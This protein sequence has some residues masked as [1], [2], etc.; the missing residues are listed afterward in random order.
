MTTPYLRYWQAKIWGLLHD[1]ALKGLHNN[2]GRGGEGQWQTLTCMAGWHSPK[3]RNSITT[4]QSRQWL[5]HVGLCDLIASASDRATIGRL[6]SGTAIDYDQDGLE[7]RHLLSGEPQ[8][9]KLSQWHEEIIKQGDNRVQW[10]KAQEAKVLDTVKG[11]ADPRQVYWW[12]WRCYPVAL[13]NALGETNPETILPLLPAETRLPDASLWS[14]TSTTSAIAGAL[15]G[16]HRDP[17]QYPPANARRVERQP[18]AKYPKSYPHLVAFTFSPVQEL[19]KASRKMRDF[20]AGS[21]LL[22]FLSARVC[23]ELAW[24]Y[25]PDIF[26]YPCLYEQ[27]LIDAWLLEKYPDFKDWIEE[28]QNRALLTAGFPNVITCILPDNGTPQGKNPVRAAMQQAES[29]LKETWQDLG[30]R[31]LEDLQGKNESW[32]KDLNPN[33]WEGWLKAQWQI[34]WIATP[35]GDPAAELHQSPIQKASKQNPTPYKTWC[36]R[37]NAIAKPKNDLLVP[38]EQA[39]LEATYQTTLEDYQAANREHKA[40]FEKRPNLNVGSWWAYI[41]DQLRAQLAAVKNARNWTIPTAFGP[42]STIS[43]IGPVVGPMGH[44]GNDWVTEGETGNVWKQRNFGLFDGIEELNA[45]EVVKRGLSRILKDVLPRNL[46]QGK[47]KPEK[48]ADQAEFKA[49]LYYPDLNAGVVGWLKAN[50]EE[51]P[52]YMDVYQQACDRIRAEFPWTQNQ[53]NDPTSETNDSTWGIPW[54]YKHYPDLPEPRFI[55][56]GWLIEDFPSSDLEEK[57]EELQKLRTT[58]QATFPAGQNPTDWYVLAA[59]DGDSMN[60]WLKGKE[61]KP[62]AEYFPEVL[63]SRVENLPEKLK[64]PFNQFSK[65]NKRMGPATHAALS[66][67]LLDFSNRLL[68]YLTE[69]RYAGRL[70]YGGG[71]D[72]LA[73]TNL[74][75]WDAWLW[76]VRQCFRGELD[77][78]EEFDNA[79]DYWHWQGA[80][81]PEGIAER[82]LFTLGGRAT[83]SFGVVIA[84]QSVPLAIALENLWAAEEGAKGH[85]YHNPEKNERCCKD[86]IQTRVLYG[87]GNSL[88]ATSKF[89]TFKQWQALL[90]FNLEPSLFEQAAQTLEQH[91]IPTKEAIAPWVNGFCDRREQVKALNPEQQ[92]EFIEAFQTWIDETFRTNPEVNALEE[93]RN[94]CKL[95]AFIKRNRGIHYLK[96]P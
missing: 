68:P 61:M 57:A 47:M 30:D 25:G 34:Y 62:Y 1:P 22:H 11:W 76:D 40:S 3:D 56:A 15:A 14:H 95:A 46:D 4:N 77:P 28:P 59:G 53:P 5:N 64:E 41:F 91:P 10:L 35:I 31:I 24:K 90:K 65:E 20:W 27:P 37:Q 72:V 88:I 7:I 94:G 70:I 21:W 73:Y 26:V 67:A 2:T 69:S 38:T 78:G 18:D 43:G 75:E 55:N 96:S 58:I 81:P 60:S 85:A 89:D 71:D 48:K 6:P 17:E 50:L 52:E 12:L 92:K 8:R 49:K 9:I 19:I 16:Y 83:I 42:R 80:K 54:V 74:W 82:P 23:W 63:L 86:A 51:H 36:D 32:I 13:A 93:L 45:T 66:R 84:H 29:A 44:E 79:G 87:N 39:F 33:T